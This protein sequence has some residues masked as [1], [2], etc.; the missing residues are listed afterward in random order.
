MW[1][2]AMRIL[3]LALRLRLCMRL[4]LGQLKKLLYRAVHL[5]HGSLEDSHP[6]LE[7]FS[8]A[9]TQARKS[10]LFVNASGTW[11]PFSR[12]WFREENSHL[13][14]GNYRIVGENYHIVTSSLCSSR[15]W[16]RIRTSTVSSCSG[17]EY[18]LDN[19]RCRLAGG[20]LT[21]PADW[22]RDSRL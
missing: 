2:G 14:A 8:I 11:P 6:V 10:F 22:W 13:S 5:F 4:D 17:G 21:S 12:D 16:T 15:N 1:G 7:T 3:T 18:A 9:R 19:T 20:S